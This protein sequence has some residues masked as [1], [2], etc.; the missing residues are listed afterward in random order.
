MCSLQPRF[1]W[2]RILFWEGWSHP[3]IRL[4]RKGKDKVGKRRISGIASCRYYQVGFKDCLRQ[5]RKSVLRL[6]FCLDSLMVKRLLYGAIRH[7]TFML[8][9]ISITGAKPRSLSKRKKA[10]P[11]LK[12]W[13][14]LMSAFHSR[15][16]GYPPLELRSG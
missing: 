10:M 6:S 15:S 8:S 4:V 11:P 14:A 12:L 9:A 3:R 16:Y 1:P 5:K 7:M 2:P 13:F